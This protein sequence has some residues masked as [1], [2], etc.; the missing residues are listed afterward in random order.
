HWLVRQSPRL[1]ILIGMD[2]ERRGIDLR[3]TTGRPPGSRRGDDGA[4]W[5]R[6]EE[7]ELSRLLHIAGR[8]FGGGAPS[9]E[10]VDPTR[11]P[12][13]ATDVLTEDEATN[14]LPADYSL[15]HLHRPHR[16]DECERP[17]RKDTW[18]GSDRAARREWHAQAADGSPGHNPKEHVGLV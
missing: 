5:V 11:A 13:G 8:K 16:P 3:P 9:P 10:D 1:V 17:P 12:N 15:R 4:L 2:I 7:V 6:D 18:V 14:R